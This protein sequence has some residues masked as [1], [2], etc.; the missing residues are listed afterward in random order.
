MTNASGHAETGSPACPCAGA[1]DVRQRLAVRGHA[2]ATAAGDEVVLRGLALS[3]MTKLAAE[4]RWNEEYF[5]QAAAWGATVVRLPLIPGNWRKLGARRCLAL[6]DDGVR[7]AKRQN[8]Y[9]ILDWHSI[10]NPVEGVFGNDTEYDYATDS[11]ETIVFWRTVAKRYRDEPAVA[12]YE[13]FNEPSAFAHLG[14][15]LSWA[16][17]RPAAE[18]VICEIYAVNPYAIPLVGGMDWAYDLRD[19]LADPISLPG[20]G[21]TCHPYP[22]KIPQAE[23]EAGWTR[24]FGL[25][26]TRF[27]LFAT[28][29]GYMPWEGGH[30]PT[31]GTAEFGRRILTYFEERGISWAVW[32]FDPNWEPPLLADW[33]FAPT[34]A[35]KLF[36]DALQ[37]AGNGDK[38]GA[39]ASTAR[40][41]RA[42]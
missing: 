18:S 19:V 27:P 21:Y 22:E 42:R 16:R 24:D 34:E 23:W 1:V 30:L 14:G 40:L 6:L 15:S 2:F 41:T 26:K 28:E 7:W 5:R 38:L 9:V 8:L 13:I 37:R 3:D 20:V 32:C 39:H 12:F 35:G 31:R 36:H 10:G 17:W 33:T 4:G 11:P 29:F 25:V